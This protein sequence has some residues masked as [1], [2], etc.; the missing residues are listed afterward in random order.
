M[1]KILFLIF[2]LFT[3]ASSLS[4]QAENIDPATL[5][6]SADRDFFTKAGFIQ[7]YDK[8]I[9]YSNE[10]ITENLL[11]QYAVQ[12]GSGIDILTSLQ[13][14]QMT[15]KATNKYLKFDDYRAKDFH[16]GILLHQTG[17]IPNGSGNCWLRYSDALFTGPGAESGVIL[18]PGDK[19]YAFS[20]Q[21]GETVY[22]EIA[23]LSSINPSERIK[24][25][26]IRL[27]GVSYFY[28]DNAFSFQYEDGMSNAVSFEAGSELHEGGNRIRCVFDNFT[29][30]KQ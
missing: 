30:R 25:D 7:K 1:K 20:N 3:L 4:V 5:L 22:K 10:F 16:A 29:Y 24:I 17:A 26:V 6:Q 9:V 8:A 18:Y 13:P 19:A 28:F 14:A 23:D 15:V 11:H 21:N 27:N 2:L 12:E